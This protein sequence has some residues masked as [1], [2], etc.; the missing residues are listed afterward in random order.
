[1]VRTIDL[2]SQAPKEQRDGN[3][4]AQGRT[5][6]IDLTSLSMAAAGG[7]GGADGKP[8]VDGPGFI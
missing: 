6:S 5:T 7:V 3:H 8:G 2:K 1:M 4:A